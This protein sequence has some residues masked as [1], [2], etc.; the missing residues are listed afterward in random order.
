MKT[1]PL[2]RRRPLDC[3]FVLA[4]GITWGWAAIALLTCFS[5]FWLA[6]LLTACP[7]RR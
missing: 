1:G 7:H 6:T 5:V 2:L 4:S 3:Y